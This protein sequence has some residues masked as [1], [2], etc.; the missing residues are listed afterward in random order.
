[1]TAERARAGRSHDGA[2]TSRRSSRSATAT[3]A[4]PHARLLELQH[5]VGNRA[6]QRAAGTL[7]VRWPPTASGY[8]A[9]RVPPADAAFR[10]PSFT[11]LKAAYKSATLAIPES[12]IKDRVAVLLGR[13]AREKKLTSKDPVPVIVGK[14]FPGGGVID[15]TEFEKALDVTDRSLVY[16]TVMDAEAK[17]KAGDKAKLVTAFTEAATLADSVKGDTAGL[18][19]VFGTKHADAGRVYGGA[20]RALRDTARNLDTRVTTDYNLDDPQVG[21]GGWASF[22]SKHM[23][24]TLEVAKVADKNETKVT[25]VHEGAHLADSSVDDHG[26]YAT[27]NFEALDEVTKVGNAAHYEELVRRK[28]GTSSF[29]GLTF[30][31]GTLK[32]GKPPT[33]EDN[34]RRAAV[35]HLRKAWD[36]AVDLHG[37][38]RDVR[39]EALG[40]N[41]AP[42][43]AHKA[44]ILD[45][46]RRMGLTVHEQAATHARVTALDI[47]LSEG[48]ARAMALV[49]RLVPKQPIPP[50]ASGPMSL[51]VPFLVISGALADYGNLL[52]DPAKDMALVN[53]LAAGYRTSIP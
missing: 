53:W 14:I 2:G 41:R 35:Q 27:P 26:Y 38:L 36:R 52:G 29:A 30:K 16:G 3:P 18:K 9:R 23:H 39:K 50:V 43:I 31:P 32:T 1:M 6:V 7:T 37:F 5:S 40:G 42:F 13:L 19:Q 34:V 25:L 24:L 44:E 20:A 21:L 10:V 51:L 22:S 47:T 49:Q 33:F 4:S 15:Q 46:S 28:L 8:E 17:V 12:V 11:D 45:I 48:V